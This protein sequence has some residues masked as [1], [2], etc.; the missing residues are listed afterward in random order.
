MTDVRI[1]DFRHRAITRWV[2][3]GRPINTIMAATG[4]RTYSAFL[5]YAN[6]REG[7]V[8]ALV[9]RKTEQLPVLTFEEYRRLA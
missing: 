7:D 9:G 5:R 8:Q 6:L 3:E 1:H 2:K 4:H